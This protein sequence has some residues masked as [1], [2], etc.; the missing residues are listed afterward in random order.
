[1]CIWKSLYRWSLCVSL[2]SGRISILILQVKA[3]ETSCTVIKHT[4]SWSDNTHCQIYFE[5][6]L[7]Q[8]ITVD[9]AIC[10]MHWRFAA[11][12]QIPS[13]QGLGTWQLLYWYR[14]TWFVTNNIDIRYRAILTIKH[15]CIH[16]WSINKPF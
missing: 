5:D 3:I 13:W 7:N 10:Y 2:S 11:L 8:L 15:T 12:H 1:M 9:L 16:D 4:D 6:C 14:Q